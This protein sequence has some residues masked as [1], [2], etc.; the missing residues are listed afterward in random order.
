MFLS[1]FFKPYIRCNIQQIPVYSQS[2]EGLQ[3]KAHSEER[4]RTW[5]A[6]PV[7][8]VISAVKLVASKLL[9]THK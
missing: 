3:C 6:K 9:A 2:R 1:P 5:S 8:G 7:K 4:A